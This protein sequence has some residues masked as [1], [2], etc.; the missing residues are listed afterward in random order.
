MKCTIMHSTDLKTLFYFFF[1]F[2]KHEFN[3]IDCCK[4]NIHPILFSIGQGVK[5]INIYTHVYYRKIYIY[6]A[7]VNFIH[8]YMPINIIW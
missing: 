5:F 4:F 7:D 8:K 6:M 1:S 2:T 3:Y